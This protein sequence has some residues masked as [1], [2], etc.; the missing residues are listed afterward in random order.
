MASH[1]MAGGGPSVFH[2]HADVVAASAALLQRGFAGVG[3]PDASIGKI[4]GGENL[5]IIA[6]I[7]AREGFHQLS[8]LLFAAMRRCAV[9]GDDHAG[10]PGNQMPLPAPR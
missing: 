1:P 9:G 10:R 3:G 8:R 6:K 7:K 5:G 4:L 2:G